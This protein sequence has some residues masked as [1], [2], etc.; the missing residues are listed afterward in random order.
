MER[1]RSAE[2]L[3]WSHTSISMR[4][5]ISCSKIRWSASKRSRHETP[6]TVMGR[7]SSL[8]VSKSSVVEMAIS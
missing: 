8:K 3:E 4:C 1:K 6:L 2:Q 7:T 5:S